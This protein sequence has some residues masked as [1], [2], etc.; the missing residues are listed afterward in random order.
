MQLPSLTA[1]LPQFE[2]LCMNGCTCLLGHVVHPEEAELGW[3]HNWHVLHRPSD[4][5][6]LIA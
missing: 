6:A 5:R 1:L 2:A 3:L 4:E